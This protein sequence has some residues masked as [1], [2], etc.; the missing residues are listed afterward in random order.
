MH[1]VRCLY[2]VYPLFQARSISNDPVRD[3]LQ[4]LEFTRCTSIWST[5]RTVGQR[6]LF[7]YYMQCRVESTGSSNNDNSID[8]RTQI[9]SP[10]LRTIHQNTIDDNTYILHVV[11]SNQASIGL[12]MGMI[13]TKVSLT[14]ANDYYRYKLRVLFQSSRSNRTRSIHDN[15]VTIIEP[16]LSLRV[17]R[18][19][20][21][22]NDIT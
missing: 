16:V 18:W 20:D 8:R 11:S 4:C 21:K 2:H 14:M 9:L 7:N 3:D 22:P 5:T 13:L 17:Y 10:Y 1:I 12:H 6:V 15:H 19:Y